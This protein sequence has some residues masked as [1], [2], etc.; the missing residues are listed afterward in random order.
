MVSNVQLED[1]VEDVNDL[2]VVDHLL[3]G[4]VPNTRLNQR[5]QNEVDQLHRLTVD[6][7]I[8]VLGRE[9]GR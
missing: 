8:E 4:I 6:V 1:S 7:C 2:S 5:L 3:V 9:E